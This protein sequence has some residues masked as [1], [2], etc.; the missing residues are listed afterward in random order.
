MPQLPDR[1]RR[2]TRLL[3]RVRVPVVLATAGV[4]RDQR[5]GRRSREREDGRRQPGTM[6]RAVGANFQHVVAFPAVGILAGVS[7]DSLS[8]ARRERMKSYIRQTR[9]CVMEAALMKYQVTNPAT[10]KIES[11]Y[12]TATDAEIGAVLARA[13]SGY[14]SWKTTDMAHRAEIIARAGQLHAERAGELGSIITRE[15]GKPA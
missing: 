6:A 10:G 1:Y 2:Q 14:A 5:A 3:L 13:A 9:A 12:P 4:R 8:P 11:E 15:M 7:H